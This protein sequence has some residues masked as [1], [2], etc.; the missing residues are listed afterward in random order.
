VRPEIVGRILS[1]A[2]L[3]I[4]PEQ[5]GDLPLGHGTGILGD[6]LVSE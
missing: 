2:F 1:D 3:A 6:D 5:P 4:I